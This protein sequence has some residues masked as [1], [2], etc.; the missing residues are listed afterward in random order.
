MEAQRNAHNRPPSSGRI[1]A[2]AGL[3]VA[4]VFALVFI[5]WLAANAQVPGGPGLA[6][7]PNPDRATAPYQV[8]PVERL[9]V[10]V[11]GTA[12]H[13]PAAYTQGLV[14]HDGALFESTG[15]YGRSTL[16]KVDRATGAVLQQTELDPVYF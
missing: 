1:S 9:R 5:G 6:R 8:P 4:A 13:D 10:E 12:P 15:L 14:W 11:L 7:L 3:A 16:R 2:L